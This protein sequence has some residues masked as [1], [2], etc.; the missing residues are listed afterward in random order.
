[1]PFIMSVIAS[2]NL[3]NPFCFLRAAP[4]RPP[5]APPILRRHFAARERASERVLPPRLP[6]TF[7]LSLSVSLSVSLFFCR[8]RGEAGCVAIKRRKRCLYAKAKPK[9]WNEN[10]GRPLVDIIVQQRRPE[11][12][13]LLLPGR[14]IYRG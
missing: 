2:P 12:S 8:E 10:G 14:E 1:M 9:G 4:L 6:K 13:L 11:S 3:R 5:P 7:F